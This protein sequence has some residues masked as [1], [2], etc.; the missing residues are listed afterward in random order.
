MI[1][2]CIIG[3]TDKENGITYLGGDSCASGGFTKST[4]NQKK[5]FKLKDTNN[6]ILGFSGNVRDL[7]LLQ[8]AT[9]FIDNRDEPNI[10]EEYM[11][12]K[13]VPNLIK[14]MDNGSRCYT[15]NGQKDM[16]S[17]FLLAYKDKLWEIESNYSVLSI[18]DNYNAIGSGCYHALGSMETTEGL[19]MSPTDRIHKALQV[20][21]KFVPSVAPPFYIINTKDDTIIEFKD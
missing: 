19:N 2:T 10:D 21:S 8:Y 18:T 13:F 1:M 3:F 11:V 9:G 14:T 7:N 12:T 5:I 15:S 6:A 4:I 17:Y 16:N 20:A